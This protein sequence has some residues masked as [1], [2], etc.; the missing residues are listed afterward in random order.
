MIPVNPETSSTFVNQTSV[1]TFNITFVDGT[2]IA[3][4]DFTDTLG[5]GGT[6]LTGMTIGMIT[7][8]TYAEGFLGLGYGANSLLTQ[9][10]S[11][12]LINTK[13]FSL[14]LDGQNTS[15]SILFGGV[16]TTKFSGTLNVLDVVT[17]ANTPGTFFVNLTSMAI[18]ASNNTMIPLSIPTA[19]PVA[20][21]SGFTLTYVPSA[22]LSVIMQYLGALD[23][24]TTLGA[25]TVDCGRLTSEEGTQFNFGFPGSSSINVSISEM[26]RTFNWAP[27]TQVPFTNTCILGMAAAPP[28]GYAL[29]DTFLRSA[30]AVYSIDASQVALAQ[31][32]FNVVGSNITE[33]QAGVAIPALTG[34]LTTSPSTSNPASGSSPATST[35]PAP[36]NKAGLS[37]GAIGGIVVGAVIGL[38]L[39]GFL[40]FFCLR[41]RQ[42]NHRDELNPGAQLPVEENPQGGAVFATTNDQKHASELYTP[43]QKYDIPNPNGGVGVA[44][45]YT[46]EDQYDKSTVSPVQSYNQLNAHNTAG[47][48]KHH[49]PTEPTV[50]EL[51]AIP[52]DIRRKSVPMPQSPALRSISPQPSELSPSIVESS[53]M[54]RAV[55]PEGQSRLDVLQQRMER[56]R[57]EK[58]RLAREK[59][60]QD[61]EASLQQEIMAEL[62]K[63]HGFNQ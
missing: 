2:D 60:L 29:G 9:M 10:V 24:T 25:I 15:G 50:S 18:Y 26:I 41:R 45:I 59:E 36:P 33:L 4:Y 21:S 19:I 51:A 62:R 56:L 11:E 14:Y 47:A 8:G 61:L 16:D 6:T 49:T 37:G 40:L 53:D 35:S 54:A 13:A 38:A 32:V 5:F 42:A 30:Y 52:A 23:N 1:Q 27:G 44:E 39:L 17:T 31:A 20:V 63:E 7:Q 46:Q 48:N 43:E 22:A 28:G 55:S 57:A 3:G 12:R 58:E 34:D